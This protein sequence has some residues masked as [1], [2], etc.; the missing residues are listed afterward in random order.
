MSKIMDITGNKYGKL[1]VLGIHCH[2]TK[3]TPIKWKCIC[4]CGNIV[5]KPS[6]C[7]KNGT[8]KSCGCFQKEQCKHINYRHGGWG[9]K[10]YKIWDKMCQRCNNNKK[11]NYKNYGG[12]GINVCSEWLD[13][14][15][16]QKW[17]NNNGYKDG[18]T[19]ERI[20]NDGNYK[21]T[22]CKWITLQKQQFN[23]R[24]N[25][26][27][28]LNGEK[29][30]MKEWSQKLNI[31]YDVLSSRVNALKWSDEKALTTPVKGGVK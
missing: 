25:R 1:T 9:T 17:A 4:D 22:N 2:G 21:P 16:F 18:L 30:T 26:I 8:V 15:N 23:K 29:Q 31:N 27:L 13:F 7:L 11:N 14:A 12:R 5:Y 28:E 10:L 19:I 6:N 3:T 20:N 24:T